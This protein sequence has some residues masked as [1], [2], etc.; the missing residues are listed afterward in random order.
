MTTTYRYG[1]E[2]DEVMGV[3]F[4]K[5]LVLCKDQ[6]IPSKKDKQENTP[7]QDR[8][9]RK[10]GSNAYPF[11]FQFPANSPS[12]VTLQPGDDDQGKPLGVEYTVRIFVAEGEDDKVNNCSYARLSFWWSFEMSSEHSFPIIQ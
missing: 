10:L 12:S 9:L 7:I 11:L 3:K 2:E 8:L 4:S 5:E 6:I 1:R